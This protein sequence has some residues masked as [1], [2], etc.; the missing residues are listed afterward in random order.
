MAKVVVDLDKCVGC[1]ECLNG[2][3][4]SAITMENNKAKVDA[5]TCVEC[6]TCVGACPEH[7]ISEEE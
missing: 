2:C 5:D 1:E 4:T 6:G 3:P 7:A